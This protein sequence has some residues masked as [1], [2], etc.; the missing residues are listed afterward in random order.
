MSPIHVLLVDR[1][2]LFREGLASLLAAQSDMVVVGQAQSGAEAV[3]LAE[4]LR[5]HV[6]LMGASPPGGD[7]L[8]AIR[9]IK[10]TL[11]NTRMLLL[12]AEDD[13]ELLFGALRAGADGLVLKSEPLDVLTAH[14]RGVVRN[15]AALSR[16]MVAR[17][18][19]DY[20]RVI[21]CAAPGCVSGHEV[22]AALTLRERQ[23]LRCMAAG[24]ADKAIAAELVLSLSTVKTHVRHILAKLQVRNRHEAVERA[25]R[26]GLVA[27]PS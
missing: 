3:A 2:P 8:E 27:P 19:S 11:P 9:L 13:D 25:L 21:Q 4:S 23:V 18:L 16:S 22:P 1:Q 15:E 5:P 6:V 20:R 14:I 26:E 17:L 24:A 7:S 10:E 12:S